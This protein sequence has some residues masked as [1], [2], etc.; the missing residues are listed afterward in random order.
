MVTGHKRV[1]PR[2]PPIENSEVNFHIWNANSQSFAQAK[3]E[4]KIGPPPP[5]EANFLDISFSLLRGLVRQFQ[6]L[7]RLQLLVFLWFDF[8]SI[9]NHGKRS[10][11]KMAAHGGQVWSQFQ[12]S[13]RTCTSVP[14]PY[15][16]SVI[17]FSLVQLQK[18][19]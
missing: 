13:T 12:S 1:K 11:A 14:V 19:P 3:S 8:K 5:M 18:R 16:T 4:A 10:E 9:P 17:S 15:T 2:W 6:S 7:T